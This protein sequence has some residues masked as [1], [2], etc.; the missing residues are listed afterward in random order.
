VTQPF[1]FT[2]MPSTTGNI[3]R[4]RSASVTIQVGQN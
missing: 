3:A 1:E 2:P 4:N